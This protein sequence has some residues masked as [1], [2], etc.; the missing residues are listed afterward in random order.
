MVSSNR[1]QYSNRVGQLGEQRFVDACLFVNYQVK[2]AT[3]DQNI[4][5]HIDFFVLRPHASD[6][7]GVDVK[8]GN[9]PE[10]IWVEFKNVTGK[11]GWLF[12]KAEFFAFEMPEVGGFIMIKRHD[13]IE[14][15]EQNVNPKFVEKDKSHLHLY[16]RKGR[17]DVLTKLH[18]SDLQKIESYRILKYAQQ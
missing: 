4:H 7:T 15:C 2:P 6:W 12:G 11:A 13:L 9:H 16:Q 14:Y 1:R 17:E 10:T 8:S 5:D 3:R 18:Q